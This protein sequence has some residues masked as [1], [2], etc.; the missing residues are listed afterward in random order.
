MWG[1]NTD[2]GEINPVLDLGLREGASVGGILLSGLCL[3]TLAASTSR[4][5]LGWTQWGESR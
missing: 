5:Q 2:P 3:L 1:F 4:S